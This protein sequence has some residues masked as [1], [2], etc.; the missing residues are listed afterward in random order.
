MARA[1]AAGLEVRAGFELEFFVGLDEEDP[2][3]AHA[4]PAYSAHALLA[5]DELTAQLLGDL[6]ANGL[7]IGQ[8]HAE[9]GSAQL[10]ISLPVSDPLR[11]A[12]DQLLAR[13]TISAAA[14]SHGLR[15][16]FAPLITAAGAGQGWH[17]HTSVVR[18]ERNLL[19]GGPVRGGRELPRRV[20]ARPACDRRG[21]AHRACRRWRDF[22]RAISR[23]RTP[24]GA[25]RIARRHCATYPTRRFSGPRMPTLSSK[26]ATRR[27]T[28]IWRLPR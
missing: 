22:D 11:A 19:S 20:V 28:P 27:R 14:R 16:S 3:P 18:G 21:H 25:S 13:Q 23:A 26:R 10:E 1:A 9:Y 8:L 4:G 17:L 7:A 15:V 2:R 5:V 6:A 12:D 24:S